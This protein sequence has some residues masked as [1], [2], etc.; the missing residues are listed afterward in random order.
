MKLLSY[1]R[2]FFF[3][4]F[5]WNI[6]LAWFTISNEIRGE[7]KYHLDTSGI[8]ELEHLSINS[9]LVEFA[10]PYQG[11]N[12]YL[13]EKVFEYLRQQKA[14]K[15]IVDY[16]S[17][18]GRIMVVAAHYGFT[19][20]TG[21]DFSS[22]LCEEA[23]KNTQALAQFPDVKFT[24][25][26]AEATTYPIKKEDN[27]LFFFNPFDEV[28]MEQVLINIRQSLRQYPRKM[29]IAYINPV[30]KDV[31]EEADFEEVFYLKKMEYVEACVLT[32]T[33]S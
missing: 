16:G 22:Q 28:V 24:V 17:G 19:D 2:Y 5:N 8:I 29:Y 23:R 13:L 4:A 3:I 7:R 31:F 27:V 10:Q 20:I 33:I 30:H 12:Y 11:A 1:I 21:I 32:N 26:H 25:I 14:N 9:R 18:K 15:R 6:R